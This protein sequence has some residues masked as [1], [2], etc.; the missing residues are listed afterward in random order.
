MR[1]R[2][3][4]PGLA[5]LAFTLA[6]LASPTGCAK[7]RV[8]G[9]PQTGGSPG[10]IANGGQTATITVVGTKTSIS[11]GT[12]TTV[13]SQPDAGT[14]KQAVEC[15]GGSDCVCPPFNVAVMGKPGKWGAN[16]AGDPDTALQEWLSSRS[17]GT[18]KVAKFPDRKTLTADV[19]AEFN[20]IIL[21]GLGEDSNVGSWWTFSDAE[22]AAFRDWIENGGG[23]ITLTGY[24]GNPEETRPVNQLIGFS[25]VTYNQDG[26]NATCADWQ[27]C[28]CTQSRTFGTWN[29]TDAVVASLSN[30]VTYVGFDNGRSITAPADAHVAATI[31]GTKNALVGKLV[32]KGRVLAYADEWIT[33]TS[34]WTGEGNPSATDPKCKGLLPQDQYQTAQFWF[35]LIKWSSPSARCF[36]I[37]DST[38]PVKVW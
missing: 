17:V 28:N 19:L 6:M 12:G 22:V 23:V 32:G 13:V 34:Q 18:A 7:S 38:T 31:D 26:I 16:P 4:L 11:L 33:Y 27:I 1:I 5:S 29:K 20:V 30:D 37:V 2:N 9:E 24:S 25:G 35:N 14:V 15:E 3:C 21:A 36:T 10:P 8:V